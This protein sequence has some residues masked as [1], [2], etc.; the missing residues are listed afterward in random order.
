MVHGSGRETQKI[1]DT[2]DEE[3]TQKDDLSHGFGIS[4]LSL[5]CPRMRL[6]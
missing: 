4:T 2:S 5:V 1:Q 3:C 6:T